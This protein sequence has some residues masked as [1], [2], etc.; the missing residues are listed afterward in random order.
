[1]LGLEDIVWKQFMPHSRSTTTGETIVGVAASTT[2][3]ASVQQL[4]GDDRAVL[5][6]GLRKRDGWRLY[7]ECE[8]R[9]ADQHTGETGDRVVIDDITYEVVNTKP[10]RQLLGHFKVLVVQV[11]EADPDV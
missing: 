1:M 11:Q 2:V 7:T 3:E 4:N 9:P 6:E 10:Y 8:M 5:P